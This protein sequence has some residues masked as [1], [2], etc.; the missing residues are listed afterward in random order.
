MSACCGMFNSTVTTVQQSHEL[1]LKMGCPVSKRNKFQVTAGE[2]AS[3]VVYAEFAV[4]IKGLSNEVDTQLC[5]HTY[6]NQG[7]WSSWPG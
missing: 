5:I 4:R 3:V 1:I 7:L 2:I 6:I